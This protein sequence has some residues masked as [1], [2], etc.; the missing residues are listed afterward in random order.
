MRGVYGIVKT[1]DRLAS[2]SSIAGR[3][4]QEYLA[5]QDPP[6]AAPSSMHQWRPSDLNSYKANFDAAVFQATNTHSGNW[7]NH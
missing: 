6:P 5:V 2:I 1:P 7:C 3:M 4:L